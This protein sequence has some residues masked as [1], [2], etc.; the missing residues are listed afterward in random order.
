MANQQLKTVSVVAA[1]AA[2][3]R[4][5]L[6]AGEFA[7]GQELKD[8]QIAEEYGIARPTARMA[9]Q[10]LIA[11]GVL[12]RPPGFSARVR[13]FDPDEVRDI[14]GTRRLIELSAVRHILEQRRSLAGIED[15]LG[16]FHRLRDAEDDWTSIARADVNFH[17]AVVDA[18]GSPRLRAF[19]GGLANEIR[20][21]IALL[22]DQYAG[23][24]A[25]YREHEELFALLRG[26]SP[27]RVVEQAWGEHLDSAQTFL[28][29]HF[30]S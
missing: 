20:L 5:S 24:E 8:T 1:A 25:L 2:R 22:K 14:Y 3:L 9:V 18:A 26:D 7:A 16:D 23:G 19:F 12:V 10:Q 21:L 13:T 29:G 30:R 11:E 4:D 15:A 28:E 17:T 27:W 6:F